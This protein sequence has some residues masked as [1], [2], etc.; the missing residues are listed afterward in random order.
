MF[1]KITEVD[2]KIIKF[3]LR[4]STAKILNFDDKL[5]VNVVA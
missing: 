2:E 4:Y 5:N 1:F 3:I